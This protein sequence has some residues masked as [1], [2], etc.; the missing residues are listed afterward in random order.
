[1]ETNL[2]IKQGSTSHVKPCCP[3]LDV[4]KWIALSAAAAQ[5]ELPDDVRLPQAFCQEGEEPVSS[6]D[7]R[8]CRTAVADFLHCVLRLSARRLSDLCQRMSFEPLTATQ[9]LEQVCTPHHQGT[10]QGQQ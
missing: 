2:S 1:M 3:T 8:P 7:Q 9:V 10:S 4:L 6:S 5:M